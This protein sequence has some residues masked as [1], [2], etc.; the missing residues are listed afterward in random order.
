VNVN[1]DAMNAQ[2]AQTLAAN[3]A[4]TI[5]R[6][7]ATGHGLVVPGATTAGQPKAP[8]GPDDAVPD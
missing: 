6:M 8:L 4:G 7:L 2:A 1:H 3:L 5:A